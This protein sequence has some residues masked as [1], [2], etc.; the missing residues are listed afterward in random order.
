MKRKL[1]VRQNQGRGKSRPVWQ[2]RPKPTTH[3]VGIKKYSIRNK[4]ILAAH[5]LIRLRY[6]T[7]RIQFES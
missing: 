1:K 7:A 2:H 4:K 3:S 6:K 5:W